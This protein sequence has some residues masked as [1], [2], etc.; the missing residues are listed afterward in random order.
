[1][2]RLIFCAA[3]SLWL[4]VSPAQINNYS[5]SVS[6]VTYS[7]MQGGTPISSG[8]NWNDKSYT[9]DIGFP[10]LLCGNSYDSLT[11]CKQ[12]FINFGNENRTTLLTFLGIGCISDTSGNFSSIKSQLSGTGSNKILELEFTNCGLWEDSINSTLSYQVWLYQADGKIEIHVGPNG[13]SSLQDSAVMC[14]IGL[15]N[16]YMNSAHNSLILYGSPSNLQV[17]D[18]GEEMEELKSLTRIPSENTVLNITPSN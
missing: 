5:N 4:G 16:P 9:L 14:V 17:Q 15:V 10:F 11:I 3:L 1:M 18:I 12:G 2:K 6:T 7:A 13:F 8:E